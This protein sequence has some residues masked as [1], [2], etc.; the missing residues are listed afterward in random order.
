MNVV[1]P[2]RVVLDVE[3]YASPGCSD[4]SSTAA[5]LFGAHG[6]GH[7]ALA[8]ALSAR[9]TLLR[10]WQRARG[11][12]TRH[13]VLLMAAG[14]GVDL[15]VR[16]ALPGAVSRRGRLVS[17]RRRA[18]R[19]RPALRAR[20]GPRAARTSPSTSRRTRAR[21][22]RAG[23]P[24]AAAP[25]RPTSIQL[26]SACARA[27]AASIE[28]KNATPAGINCSSRIIYADRR[29]HSIITRACRC[30]SAVS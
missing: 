22:T 27:G 2:Q 18:Q 30:R 13:L 5:L 6:L 23:V 7:T 26:A 15:R 24:G 1:T 10:T 16:A 21:A 20:G 12:C 3:L 9:R 4:P 14:S 29:F 19:A 17:D 11:R 25:C 8:C 28:W